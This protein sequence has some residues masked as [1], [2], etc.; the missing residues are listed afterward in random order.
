MQFE[1]DGMGSA[2]QS[3]SGTQFVLASFPCPQGV[4][5]SP[6]T[7][8]LVGDCLGVYRSSR[9]VTYMM[10]AVILFNRCGHMA[11]PRCFRTGKYGPQKKENKDLGEN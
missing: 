6:G 5:F 2:P 8:T 9:E 7:L 10:P 3:H 1:G 4:P 11:P